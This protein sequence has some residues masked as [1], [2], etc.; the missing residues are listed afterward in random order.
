MVIQSEKRK[1]RYH[2]YYSIHWTD[3]K[4]GIIHVWDGLTL[5][6]ARGLAYGIESSGDSSHVEIIKRICGYDKL[7]GRLDF[8]KI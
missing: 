2:R 4:S 6:E 8:G 5:R 1:Y 7:E 3:A